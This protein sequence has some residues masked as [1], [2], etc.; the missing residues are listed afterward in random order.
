MKRIVYSD[1]KDG[2]RNF[3]I[4]THGGACY[5]RFYED[6]EWAYVH[7]ESHQSGTTWMQDM[8]KKEVLKLVRGKQN[9]AD[10]ENGCRYWWEQ[11]EEERRLMDEY[12]DD[13]IVD[14]LM[15]G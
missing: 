14:H 6:S 8:P 15:E 4:V 5:G 7:Y 1:R 9:W 10:F 13:D 3:H 11:Q 2:F 12:E